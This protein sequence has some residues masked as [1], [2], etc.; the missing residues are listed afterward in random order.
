MFLYY[1]I[2]FSITLYPFFLS[3]HSR[4][5]VRTRVYS[6]HLSAEDALVLLPSDGFFLLFLRRSLSGVDMISSQ[7]SASCAV[8]RRDGS[9]VNIPEIN[10][11]T[12]SETW[13]QYLRW[14]LYSPYR[15]F[16]KQ[17]SPSPR[18]GRYPPSRMY[19]TTPKLHMS[20]STSYWGLCSMISGATNPSVPHTVVKEFGCRTILA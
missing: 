3:I 17:S 18:N 7:S 11:F 2:L 14:N 19:R 5:F 6:L 10:C 15:I 12:S 13:D 20:H 1:C 4:Y 8:S 9:T 16:S